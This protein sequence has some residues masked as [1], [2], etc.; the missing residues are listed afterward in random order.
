MLKPV[1]RI[2]YRYFGKYV[3]RRRD[4]FTRL[5]EEL[6]VARLPYTVEEYVSAIILFSILSFVTSFATAFFL[7]FSI[8]KYPAIISAVLSFLVAVS[9]TG[10]VFVGLV[11]YPRYVVGQRK[12][13]IEGRITYATTHMA[14]LAGTGIPVVAI[15]R[16]ISR[17]SEYGEISK[18]CEYI[19]RDVEVFGKDIYTAIADAARYSPSRVWSE[20]LW[21][22]VATLRSG[23][24]LRAYLSERARALVQ[25]HE[26]EEKRAMEALNV[27]TEI[28]MV[29]FVLAPIV[30]VIMVVFMSMMGGTVLGLPAVTFLYLLEY[31]LLPIV[32]SIFIAIAEAKKP[33]E[34]I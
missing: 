21:G 23:G 11:V 1:M 30:G 14:T 7:L 26:E 5:S 32:G 29:L 28:F 10:L 16:A 9:I 2:A 25:M 18:E 12:E 8:Y 22:M 31:L 20:V 4:R 17:F 6:K 13:D 34:V 19:V 33:K 15:F 27:V 24:N 3:H